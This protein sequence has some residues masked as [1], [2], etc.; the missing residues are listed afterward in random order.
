MSAST[1]GSVTTSSTLAM[2][3]SIRRRAVPYTRWRWIGATSNRNH[4]G[5]SSLSGTFMNSCS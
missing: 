3:S 5:E 4:E 1:N 2:A